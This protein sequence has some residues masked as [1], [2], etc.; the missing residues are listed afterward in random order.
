MATMTPKEL[1]AKLGTDPKKLRAF[2]RANFS[3]PAEAKNTSWIVG[4]DAQK[5]AAEHFAKS[6]TE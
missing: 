4:E 6:S 1:A 2:L 5:A 3:R